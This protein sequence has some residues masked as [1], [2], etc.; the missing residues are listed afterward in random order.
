[1][2]TTYQHL[3]ELKQ[4]NTEFVLPTKQ[5]QGMYSINDSQLTKGLCV[6]YSSVKLKSIVINF[7]CLNTLLVS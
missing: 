6:S 4:I 2:G 5:K 1:M 3:A 7:W